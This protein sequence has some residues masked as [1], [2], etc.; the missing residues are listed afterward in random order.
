MKCD[1]TGL[2]LNAARTLRRRDGGTA[3]A[4]AELAENLRKVVAG[5]AT[6]DEF[7]AAYVVSQTAIDPD[8]EI[9]A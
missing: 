2:L 9:P 1:A 3:Y 5:E 6:L 8:R 7:R 4:L